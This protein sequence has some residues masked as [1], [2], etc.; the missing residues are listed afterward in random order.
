MNI[1]INFA[2]LKS[3]G[4]QNVALNFVDALDITLFEDDKFYFAVAQDSEIEELLLRKNISQS[5]ILVTASNPYIRIFQERTLLRRFIAANAIDIL[6]MYFG[7]AFVGNDITQVSGV[8]DSNLFFPEIDFWEGYKGLKR[9]KKKIIDNY[10]LFGYRRADGLI[11]E[12]EAMLQRA[13][14]MMGESKNCIYIK[15]SISVPDKSDVI[16]LPQKQTAD[17]QRGLFLCGWQKNKNILKIPEISAELKRRGI[18]YSFYITTD[19]DD[20]SVCK[21]FLKYV[22]EY[23][24]KD[25]IH[26]IG[27]VRKEQIKSLYGQIDHVFMMSKLESFSN[28]I[29]EAWYFRKPLIVA[30]EEWARAICHDAGIYVDRNSVKSIA[31]GIELLSDEVEK[32]LIIERGIAELSFYPSIEKKTAEELAYVKK[33][34]ELCKG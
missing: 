12:N 7:Y 10:R 23:D 21:E 25:S 2:T 29:I 13:K 14:Q 30:D 28:N 22:K 18:K 24:S 6:Y 32:R 5:Q 17:E 1:L 8:A 26:L 16:R 3:G 31:D 33:I 19:I 9:L 11:F 34:A 4:G 20:S 15:P 27:R